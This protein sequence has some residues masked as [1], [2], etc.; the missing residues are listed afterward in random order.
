MERADPLFLLVSLPLVPVA[1]VLGK[2][3]RWDEPV[4]KTLRRVVPKTPILRNILPAFSCM[5][6]QQ[7]GNI[8]LPPLSNEVSAT[9]CGG[10]FFPTIAV[11]LGRALFPE[12]FGSQMKR[13]LFGG[14]TFVFVK[15]VFEALPQ[16]ADLHQTL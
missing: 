12:T 6:E 8:C 9:F 14:L 5:P 2:M 10:L 3:I 13:T 16:S 11:F 15:G 1:L 4:L 7:G